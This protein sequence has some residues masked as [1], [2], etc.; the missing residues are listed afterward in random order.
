[1]FN[2]VPNI[3]LHLNNGHVRVPSI[4]NKVC[5]RYMSRFRHT[6]DNCPKHVAS[7][8]IP[9]FTAVAHPGLCPKHVTMVLYI[10][11]HLDLLFT[12]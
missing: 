4:Y 12:V 2:N 9:R 11:L 5:D 10:G 7:A 1:M 6:L 3:L 8:H